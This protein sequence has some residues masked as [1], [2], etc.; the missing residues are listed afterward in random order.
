[1][2]AN[3]NSQTPPPA[4]TAE[5]IPPHNNYQAV[6]P[7]PV[8]PAHGGGVL[9]GFWSTG[10]CGCYSDVSNSC[11]VAGGVYA[12]IRHSTG[13]PC[14]YS[15]FYRSKLRKQYM[16]DG[17]NCTDCMVH[18]CCEPCALRQEYREL[19]YRG[20]DMSLSLKE[21]VEGKNQGVRKAPF[22]EGGMSR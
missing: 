2:N 7:P 18:C 12:L 21:I 15:C 22:V 19:K 3:K 5:P 4:T 14:F 1:M 13:C 9:P 6:Q 16:I 20:F 10:L 17:N 8:Q 11:L